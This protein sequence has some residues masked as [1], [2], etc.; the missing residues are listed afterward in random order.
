MGVLLRK[1][2]YLLAFVVVGGLAGVLGVA[3]IFS[4]YALQVPDFRSLSDYSPWQI[5]KLYARDGDLL[6]EY[7]RERR[8]YIP[9]ENIP[10]PVIE[11]FL[12]AEDSSFY[13]HQGFDPKGIMRAVMVNIFTD[14]K[15]G[16]ST[17]TQQVAKTFLLSNERTYE[18]KIKE[19]ILAYRIEKVF[20]KNE[21]LE[22]YL[23]QIFLGNG[24]Y[25]VGAAALAYFNKPLEDLSIGQR[26]L[27]AGLP[28]APS[29]Y[30]PLRNP[31]A[32]RARRDVILERM[33]DERYITQEQYEE[34]LARD[35]ELA[36]R[37]LNDG[38]L[39][40]DFTEYVRRTLYDKYGEDTLYQGGLVVR[41][42]IDATLQAHAMGAVRR[43]LRAYDRR[44]GWRG[45]LG[46]A[47]GGASWQTTIDEEF[48][49]HRH[50]ADFATPAIVLQIDDTGGTANIGL[51]GNGRGIIPF[52]GLSWARTH[53]DAETRGDAVKK[54]SDVLKKGDIVFVA[55]MSR[56]PAD[57]KDFQ[58]RDGV[59]S[60]EQIPAAQGALV[61]LDART[62][63]IRA[64]VG[65][66]EQTSE[67]NRAVQAKRQVGSAFKPFVYSLAL[68]SGHTP[69]SLILDAPVVFRDSAGNTWKPQNYTE[70]IYGLT[71]LRI[72]LEKSRNLMTVRLAMDLGIAN[73]IDS[74]KRFGLD[75]SDMSR[76]LSTALGTTSLTLM[77]V[78][79]AYLV[80]ANRGTYMPAYGVESI[81]DGAGRTV[82]RAKPEACP[83]C[84]GL[85]VSS[86]APDL[87]PGGTPVLSPE[88]A[89]QM[90][91]LLRGVVN[92]GT[93][94][95][96][97]G[98]G[99]PVA[100]KTGTTNDYR[101]AW[102]IGYSPNLVTGVWIGFDQPSTLG[103]DESGSKAAVPM[104]A[105][106][107][108]AAMKATPNVAFAIPDG[109]YFQRIDP[110]T[111]QPATPASKR[112][113]L[114]VFVKNA[115]SRRAAPATPDVNADSE[116]LAAVEETTDSTD[117]ASP[118]AD[119]PAV[120]EPVGTGPINSQDIY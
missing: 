84:A 67:F 50:L 100:G 107:M 90:T 8:V 65:G 69:A 96:A 59:Y 48:T 62:G 16:A 108:T 1:L 6:A 49:K 64:M 15:Q 31:R 26:A 40:P 34:A 55:P 94:T 77:E 118:S 35:L 56:Y 91:D 27:L 14:R 21:I 38:R 113:V 97:K 73:V 86:K 119:E 72:G 80:F 115:P 2:R 74:T 4:Y 18:R 92:S 22:L 3:F 81:Q 63:A 52:A 60:L 83:T 117:P 66:F 11:A 47:A 104:W 105:D 23:N 76:T 82:W 28:K 9:I 45:P 101:D 53:I 110:T 24:A 111:G 109:V 44:H 79:N 32:A 20:S 112:T 68:E 39:A 102:F 106:F 120:V 88:L 30:N 95:G 71:T 57:F 87:I 19:L 54:V 25:G 98:V 75:T 10:K 93:G 89:F 33:L 116:G 61:A 46:R 58:G 85:A 51:P 29:T 17:I 42:T 41:T 37:P 78:T 99:V 12:A 70:K 43:G 36:P 13:N 5:T 7:A 114:E 103:P